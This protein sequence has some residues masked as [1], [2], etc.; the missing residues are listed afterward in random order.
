MMRLAIPKTAAFALSKSIALALLAAVLVPGLAAQAGAQ[1]L[2][3]VP[4]AL[5]QELVK[6]IPEI[7]SGYIDLNGNGKGDQGGDVNEI[8]PESRV[9]DGQLQ[10]QEILDFVV[11]NWRF[12]SLDKLRAVQ[13]AVKSASG[14]INELIALDFAS[15]LEDAV[16]QKYAMGDSLYLTPSA[17]KEAM[18]KLGGIITSMTT[19]YKQEGQ[20][21]ET[22]FVS[23]RD[24]LFAMIEKGYPLPGDLSAEESATLSTAMLSTAMKEQKANPA[25]AHTAIK[26]LGRLGPG[27]AGLGSDAAP[28]LLGLVDSPDF[29]LD[30]MR[31]LGDIGYKPALPALAK[32]V[33]S[34]QS[35]DARKAAL[36][37]LGEIGGSEGLDA[38][39]ELLKPANKAALPKDFLPWI[40]QALAG[41]AQKGNADARVQAALK[42][43]SASDDPAARRAAVAGMGAF[44]SPAS[45]DALLAVLAGDKD[46]LVRAQAVAALGKQ[47]SDAIAPALMKVLRE[48]DLDPALEIAAINA[49]GD[50]P[51]GSQAVQPIVDD[52]ADKDPLVRAAAAAALLKLYPANQ[53]L[54][55]GALSRSLLASQDEAFLIEGTSLLA[56][57][58]D[59]TTLPALLSLLQ[60]PSPE[61]KRNVAWAFYKIRSSSNPRVPDELQK[62]ATNESE[63]ISVRVSSVR[64]LGAIAFDSPQLNLWQT[65]VTTT[66]M[67]G[68]KYATLRYYAVW[69][70]GR[71]GAGKPQAIAALSR[72][73]SRD[74]DLEL[75]KQAVAALR[76]MASPDMAAEEALAAAFPQADDPELR[77]LIL[78]ALA[79]MGSDK[80]AS[81]AGDL[82]AGKASL[83]VKRRAMS[84]LAESPDGASAAALLDAARDAQLQ[85]LA[86]ALLEGYPSSFMAPLV[87]RRLKSETDKNVISVLQSLDARFSE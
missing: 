76:D 50:N 70:L 79:D 56:T 5:N 11:A 61:V 31:A 24:A 41:V 16:R 28:F 36:Q 2:K 13:T 57:I 47:K 73:A 22:D 1:A 35:P 63:A 27:Q 26:T 15:S 7:A 48:R 42:D 21:A 32:Q 53:A 67:R 17:Y 75:R 62:L 37:A 18:D 30:A 14:A 85:D 25:K 39:L 10:A 71:V 68:E 34:G 52:L 72:I 64:A 69:A 58:A 49:L 82:L 9:K 87:S 46:P 66:Q 23:G 74:A 44:A 6:I 19:A 20:K 78:E 4:S 77:V 55:S 51:S 81:L 45:S 33:K 65:L 38:I 60:K 12:L 83:A 84:A 8:I 59:P 80:G 86:E 54:V 40:A 43:L 3:P 29:Q